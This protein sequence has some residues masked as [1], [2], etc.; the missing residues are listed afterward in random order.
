MAKER[1]LTIRSTGPYTA[2]PHLA[3]HFILGQILPRCFGPVSSNV[4]PRKT[5]TV[6]T[7]PPM[8]RPACARLQNRILAV[9]ECNFKPQHDI[10]HMSDDDRETRQ[11]AF[12]GGFDKAKYGFNRQS[13]ADI[14]ERKVRDSLNLGNYGG[15]GDKHYIYVTA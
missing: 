2:C 6:A 15:P 8:N 5:T 7:P 9:P 14:G 12:E 3:R 1:R 10:R 11:T 4:M 13:L